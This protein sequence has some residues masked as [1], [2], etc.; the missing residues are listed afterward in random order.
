MCHG[1]VKKY[2]FLL[3]KKD[4]III[5]YWFYPEKT[6]IWLTTAAIATSKEKKT[7]LAENV[8]WNVKY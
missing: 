1:P 8:T 6:L 5:E 7:K 4:L 3:Y 2:F